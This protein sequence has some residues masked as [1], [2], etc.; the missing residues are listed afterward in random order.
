M[1]TAIITTTINIPVLLED[2][3]R[4][5]QRYGHSDVFFVVIGDRKTPAGI[6]EFL[7][8][9][10]ARYP[11]TVDYWDPDRQTAW[12]AKFPDLAAL[13]P[14][15][16]IQRRNLAYLVAA[17]KGA[18]TI[19]TI[20]DDNLVTD[21]DFVKHHGVVGQ[22]RSFDAL[23]S[24]DGWYNPCFSLRSDPPR[25]FYHRGFPHSRRW[26]DVE[27]TTA[28]V[29]GRIVV[30]AGLWL[31]APDVDAITHLEEPLSVT[32]LVARD[33]RMDEVLAKGTWA[34]FNSQNTAFSVDLLPCMYLLVMGDILYGLKIDRYDDI[35]M[36]YFTRV[37]TDHLGD[38]MQV[39]RP[40]VRQERNPHNFLVDLSRELPG[41]LLTEKLVDT[42][43]AVRLTSSTYLDGYLELADQ[44]R[45]AVVDDRRY[46]HEEALYMFK[47]TQG[48]QTWAAVC[49]D[50]GGFH[51]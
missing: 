49:R 51:G 31:S 22:H 15:N 46:T 35:W 18:E 16:S 17:E 12:L 10:E 2:Y 20:D 37:L 7:R 24:S 28:P 26:A 25:R 40:L 9:L 27:L 30:N 13:L 14:W 47:L 4:N 19:V 34:P 43:R 5:L 50:L 32:Q 48:M 45:Q 8:G 33:G 3:M 36:S 23:V 38:Y 1:R 11:Y 41:M 6:V 39:G 21:D 44:L 29:A 42:L